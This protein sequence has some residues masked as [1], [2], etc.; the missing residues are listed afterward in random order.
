M[1]PVST[2]LLRDLESY[3]TRFYR[4]E[5]AGMRIMFAWTTVASVVAQVVLATASPQGVSTTSRC[6]AS[7]GLTCRGSTF[8]QCCSQYNYC[9]TTSDHC[10]TGCQSAYGVC[11][12]S[13]SS[14]P[15][16]PKVSKDGK[17]GGTDSSTC[18]GST[19]GNCCRYVKSI[20][21]SSCH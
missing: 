17:C 7:F 20:V 15:T 1:L 13:P 10:G 2:L 6:G 4:R 12:S 19:F 5:I 8:G 14:T 16:S 21:I 11:T 3:H 9:G 18:L